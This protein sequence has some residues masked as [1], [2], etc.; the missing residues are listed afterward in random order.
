VTAPNDR[1]LHIVVPFYDEPTTLEPCVRRVLDAMLPTGWHRQLVLVD[2]HSPKS[3]GD[4]ATELV[5]TLVGEGHPVRLLRHA[6]NRGKGAA[7]RSGFDD[8]L[9]HA[10]DAA[11]DRDVAIIQDA[12]LEYDPQD[13]RALLRPLILGE[14]E[15]VFGNRWHGAVT[16]RGAYGFVHRCGNGALT[17]LSNLLTGLRVRDMECCYK[18]IPIGVLRR[19]RPMLTE[20]RFGIEPQIAAALARLGCR[21]AQVDVAYDPRGFGSGKKIRPRDAVAALMVMLRERFRPPAA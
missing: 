20:D 18:A 3:G 8:I 5:E 11:F 9:S 13:Y 19:L 16:R 2:D 21:V 7:V 1:T 10:D 6:S 15:A 12:D 14:A 4:A 17:A